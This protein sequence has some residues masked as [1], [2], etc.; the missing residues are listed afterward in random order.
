[1]ARRP[2]FILTSLAPTMSRFLPHFTQYPMVAMI[3]FITLLNFIVYILLSWQ[4]NFS[5]PFSSFRKTNGNGLL[6]TFYSCMS[7]AAVKLAALVFVH[8][9]FNLLLRFFTVFSSHASIINLI[10][11][12]VHRYCENSMI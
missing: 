8:S 10:F 3:Y 1:M 9:F 6:A 4:R 2:P 12:N 5:A 11:C 7:L